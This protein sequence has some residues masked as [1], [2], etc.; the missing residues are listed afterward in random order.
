MAHIEAK[1]H[2]G[3]QGWFTVK[4]H[5]ADGDVNGEWNFPNLITNQGLDRMA[6]NKDYLDY[7]YV[8]SGQ[9]IP[10][11][12]DTT[13]QNTVATNVNT[14][15]PSYGNSG[16]SPYYWWM[17]KSFRFGEGVAAGNL[18]EVGI[19]WGGGSLFSR[20]LI[21]DELGNPATITV[22]SNEFLTVDYELRIYPKLTDDTGTVTFTGSKGGTYNWIFRSANVNSTYWG[23]ER[24]PSFDHQYSGIGLND[25]QS[26]SDIGSVTSQ[27]SGLTN[28]RSNY[29][30]VASYTPGTY[31]LTF[32]RSLS[33]DQAN[34]S[35]GLRSFHF[36]RGI[37][38][39]QIQFDPAIPKEN[40]DTLSFTY[41][42]K[43]G[44]I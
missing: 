42:I 14:G 25:Y 5:N 40:T 15:S 34:Y 8:G 38:Q 33:I 41:T 20:T 19:G 31:S 39:Y 11:F 26:D 4:K 23:S 12:T 43:W 36:R 44:R 22:L 32:T 30:S 18:S 10:A 13:L 1:Q 24:Y 35:T 27:P 7:C 17:K 6:E 28:L 37:G 16:V 9:A 3:C 2:V 29:S 21:L